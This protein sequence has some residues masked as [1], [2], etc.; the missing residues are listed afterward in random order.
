MQKIIEKY[1][2]ALQDDPLSGV[3]KCIHHGDTLEIRHF[4]C[5]LVYI[6][7]KNSIA[8]HAFLY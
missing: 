7:P 8:E 2:D 6:P 3:E 1:Y 4:L 5:A